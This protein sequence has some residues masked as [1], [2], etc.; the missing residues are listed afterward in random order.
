MGDY[1]HIVWIHGGGIVFQVS[2]GVRQD[3]VLSPLLFTIYVDSLLESLRA[4]G[5]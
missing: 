4:C 2:N 3:G 1:D 5:Q